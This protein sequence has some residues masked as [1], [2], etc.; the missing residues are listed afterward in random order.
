MTAGFAAEYL[1]R[2]ADH[3]YLFN[4]MNGL[5]GMSN[6]QEFAEVLEKC[7]EKESVYEMPRRHVV[8]YT[9]PRPVGVPMD[10]ALPRTLGG[11]WQN[12]R[13]NVGGG[14]NCRTGYAVIGL[15]E[16]LAEGQE[17]SVKANGADCLETDETFDLEFPP[18]VAAT[19]VRRIPMRELHDGDNVLSVRLDGGEATAVWCEIYLP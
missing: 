18:H 9:T 17:I 14:T 11:G 4:Y 19:V 2:G 5:T 15:K 6:P 16:P 7:G 10:C 3:V 13:V 1:H 12:F 8:T